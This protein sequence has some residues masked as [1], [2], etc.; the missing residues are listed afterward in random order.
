MEKISF[1]KYTGAGND[2]V[3]LDRANQSELQ[4][5]PGLVRSLCNR[6][7]GVGGDGLL[8]IDPASEKDFS[9][10]YYNADGSTGTLCGNGARCAI[11]Y[12]GSR[13]YFVKNTT[14]LCGGITYSGETFNDGIVK[15]DLQPVK[16]IR[17]DISLIVD[18][19]RLT[20]SF[21][22]TGSPHLV[23]FVEDIKYRGEKNLNV[24]DSLDLVPVRELGKKLRYH[25]EF[26]PAGVNV[27]FV[28]LKNDLLYIRTYER[29]VENETLACGTGSTAAA[30]IL[31]SLEKS[32]EMVNLVVRSGARLKVN[33][34]T[35]A[36][37]YCDI[38]LTG[39]AKKVF[40]GEILKNNIIEDLDG[41]S[42]FFDQI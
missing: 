17:N 38:A 25:K 7:F 27:N 16:E 9:M 11:S 23:I 2:F 21:A 3:L 13:E 40:S 37:G 1:E 18:D 10:E 31:H 35:D 15:F 12:A 36:D 39:P 22:D 42:D 20:G 26:S 6:R 19:Y 24:Y 34:A 8:L 5:T 29:G 41:K 32:G 4:I 30:L 28:E 33:F 14:F